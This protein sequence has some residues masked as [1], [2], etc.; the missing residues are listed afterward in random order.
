MAY[1][2]TVLVLVDFYGKNNVDRSL[3][4]VEVWHGGGT[5]AA[6]AVEQN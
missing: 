6:Y 5:F 2:R 3:D 4:M 1:I